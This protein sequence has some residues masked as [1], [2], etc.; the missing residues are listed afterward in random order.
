MIKKLTIGIVLLLLL[1]SIKAQ[2]T[3]EKAQ[4]SVKNYLKTTL[5]DPS[6][7][8]PV[9]FGKLEILEGDVELSLSY[10]EPW[11]DLRI[12]GKVDI[13]DTL[14]ISELL[15]H[16][17]NRSKSFNIVNY[18]EVTPGTPLENLKIKAW[19]YFKN[20]TSIFNSTDST[21]STVDD[22]WYVKYF[23]EDG[24]VLDSRFTQLDRVPK[25]E[26][27]GYSINHIYYAMT[28]GGTLRLFE[29]KF[30]LSKS[31]KVVSEENL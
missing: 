27:I 24:T 7:Y 13:E 26:K 19:A 18:W 22:S 12:F 29:S 2:T 15:K 9:S 31:L 16:V 11:D 8:K 30:L 20:D 10:K 4:L 1:G 23:L 21:L 6:K 28:K 17:K 25:V 5:L 3:T 14:N